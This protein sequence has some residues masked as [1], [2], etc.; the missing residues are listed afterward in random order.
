MMT[1]QIAASKLTVPGAVFVCSGPEDLPL[2]E[3]LGPIIENG[4]ETFH[5]LAGPDCYEVYAKMGGLLYSLGEEVRLVF[6][7]NGNVTLHNP[8]NEKDRMFFTIPG[9]L[10]LQ[11]FEFCRPAD[12]SDM[13]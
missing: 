13:G 6:A 2:K 12:S 7:Q 10:F 11:D 4:T 8:G 5:V 9:W 1:Q 3:T